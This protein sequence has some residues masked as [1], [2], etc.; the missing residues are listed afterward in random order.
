MLVF[1]K[2][3]I[4]NKLTIDDIFGLL[5]EWG[6]DPMFTDFGIISST[7]C[8]NKPGDGSRK[9][10]YYENSGL[11]HCYTGCETPSFD[12]FELTIKIF[13]IQL[14][15]SLDL[16]EAVRFIAAKLGFNGRFEEIELEDSLEDWDILSNYAR[17][18]NIEVNEITHITLK[19]YD[20]SILERFNYSLKLTPWL[21]EGISEEAIR[22]AGIGF[23]PG[24]D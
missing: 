22:Q 9:L 17:I 19:E 8:H 6:G 10:Y 4:R 23:Y 12:I 21:E 2:Q 11:F 18:Q 3:E 13:N 7:I 20:N 24:G 15:K 1:D 16:N 5:Q 14:G